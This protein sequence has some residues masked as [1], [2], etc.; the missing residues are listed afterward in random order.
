M[1]LI[2]SL[3]L[4]FALPSGRPMPG[5]REAGFEMS[6]K[7]VFQIRG[8][9]PVVLGRILSGRVA[10]GDSAILVASSDSLRTRV[11]RIEKFRHVAN[12]AS[13]GP[14]DVGVELADVPAARVQALVATRVARL[15]STHQVELFPNA[16]TAPARVDR[17]K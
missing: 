11:V 15:I 3:F 2:I 10:V 17:P 8:R 5:S 14:G 6:L 12:E 9:G 4:L 16:R 7:D 13:A 1:T